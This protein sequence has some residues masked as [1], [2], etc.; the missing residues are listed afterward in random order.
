MNPIPPG[1]T[2]FPIPVTV[3]LE[4]LLLLT[5]VSLA[6]IFGMAWREMRR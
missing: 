6:I 1:V 5:V 3:S 4:M 2:S